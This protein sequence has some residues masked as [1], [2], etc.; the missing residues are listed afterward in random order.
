ML[1]SL[2]PPPLIYIFSAF[3]F[4]V[5][6]RELH[7]CGSHLSDTQN[8]FCTI[9]EWQA[10]CYLTVGLAFPFPQFFRELQVS[11]WRHCFLF[12]GNETLDKAKSDMVTCSGDME[13]NDLVTVACYRRSLLLFPKRLNSC[14]ANWKEEMV[15]KPNHT[16]DLVHVCLSWLVYIWGMQQG[17]MRV[18]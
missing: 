3:F 18:D 8:R 15:A 7:F 9:W 10:L 6:T 16:F 4:S 1:L 14:E 17:I 13:E 11:V 12:P 5:Q 2:F